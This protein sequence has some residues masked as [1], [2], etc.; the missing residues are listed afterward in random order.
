MTDTGPDPTVTDDTTEFLY[1]TPGAE[2]AFDDP[3][4]C[5]EAELDG[6]DHLDSPTI[7]K[8]TT[9][10]AAKDLPSVDYTIEW[11][12]E[13]AAM[14]TTEDGYKD[15]EYA[16]GRDDVK[17]A[18]RVALDLL[19]SHVHYRLCDRLV[20]THTVTWTETGEPLLDGEPMYR[21]AE[22]ATA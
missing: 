16:G 17:A 8:W 19:A 4:A 5:Y 12:I 18:F 22:G 9:K 14:E 21:K 6:D 20:G 13:F 2:R 11:V 7:Q 15:W 10:A 3:A 1:S